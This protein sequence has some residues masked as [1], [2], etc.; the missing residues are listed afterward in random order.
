[1]AAED[2]LHGG[3]QADALDLWVGWGGRGGLLI[4]DE[5]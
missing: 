2:G 5:V 3:G 4:D 1:M